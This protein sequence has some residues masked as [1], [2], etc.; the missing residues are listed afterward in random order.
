[1]I[2]LLVTTIL[3]TPILPKT[4]LI[5]NVRA[6]NS[7]A[8]ITGEEEEIPEGE[9]DWA[10]VLPGS[11]F[12]TLGECIFFEGD[13]TPIAILASAI[14]ADEDTNNSHILFRMTNSNRETGRLVIYQPGTDAAVLAKAKQ[15]LGIT[16]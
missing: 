11:L 14:E 3:T 4:G 10:Y 13:G 15:V 2:T 9:Y 8:L 16:T 1:M 12:A 6:P 7:D 5:Y